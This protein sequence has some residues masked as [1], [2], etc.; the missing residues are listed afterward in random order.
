MIRSRLPAALLVA[1]AVAAHAPGVSH[2]FVVDDG[3][4][5]FRNR[6]V[7]DGAPLAAFFFDRSTTSSRAD[8]NTRIYRP[9]RNLAFR[10]VV[11]LA[12]VRPL[13]FGLANLLSYALAA[14]L[15]LALLRALVGDGPAAAWATALW[16]VLPVHVEAVAYASALGDQLSLA[17]ELAALVVLLPRAPGEAWR[18]S[19]ARLAASAAL[20]AAAM[21]AKEMAVTEPA[22]LALLAV[23]LGVARARRV[24]AAVALH[25]AVALAYVA[26][27]THVVG[28]VGQEP[29]TAHGLAAGLRDAPWLLAHYLWITVAPLGHAASYRVA[30]PGA[31]ALV[32]T[33]V[34]IAAALWLGF[35]RRLV[36]VGLVWFAL[37]LTPVLHLVPLWADL[38]D[39]FALF[40]SVGL[41]LSLAAALAPLRRGVVVAA[42]ALALVVYAAASVVEAR[43]WRSDS[44][45][46]RYAV[47]RQP[48]AP[49]ARTNLAAVLLGEGRLAEAAAQL[50]AFHALGW[51]RADVE[52]KRAYVLGRLGRADE[53]ARAVDAALRLDP[54]SGPAHA[55]AGQLALAHGDRAGAARELAAARAL[56]PAHP[57][58][59]LLAL[60]LAGRDDERADYL[61]A[62]QALSFDD[63]DGAARAARAC[64]ARAPGRVQCQAALGRALTLQGPLDAEARALLD[65]CIADAPDAADRRRCREAEWAAQ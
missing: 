57:S 49:M 54:A 12:G 40:P 17:L 63:A 32:A 15:V 60:A 1:L 35:R 19:G 10:A 2:R 38:A 11:R 47:D 55:L 46:W 34:G 14:L 8:Y 62:L 9:L 53:A 61:G 5:I 44:L 42:L 37:S 64:L 51:T 56:A 50:E 3:V 30:P 52:L 24:Q 65:R 39:R 27:R 31:P 16:I 25:G 48:D 33:L 4:Q 59:A 26:L 41:A 36:G 58:T 22:L 23:A 20:A 7:T 6:A 28:A 18:L 43:A 45:L 13:A 21:L 29:L